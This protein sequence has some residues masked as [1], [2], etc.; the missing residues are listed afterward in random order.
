[1]ASNVVELFPAPVHN[2]TPTTITNDVI[3]WAMKY[4]IDIQDYDFRLK[5]TTLVTL[6][7]VI[8]NESRKV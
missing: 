5:A 4:G 6:M 1:M 7:Q 8:F 3:D 2:I